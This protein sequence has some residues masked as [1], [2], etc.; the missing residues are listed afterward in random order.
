MPD[1]FSMERYRNFEGDSG[2]KS[3]EIADDAIKVVFVGVMYTFNHSVTGKNHVERMKDL[4]LK[5]KG[6][7]KYI[8]ENVKRL[9]AHKES[10]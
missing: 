1:N 10:A 9:Y 3:Y 4:A 2:I 5:G 7:A 6:L 8:N